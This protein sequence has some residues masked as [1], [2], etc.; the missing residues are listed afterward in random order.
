MRSLALA[1]IRTARSRPTSTARKRA[2][3]SRLATTPR[4][5][6]LPDRGRESRQAPAA[7]RLHPTPSLPHRK[8]IW[9]RATRGRRTLPLAGARLSVRAI[10][11]ATYGVTG[12]QWRTRPTPRWVLHPFALFRPTHSPRPVAIA[13]VRSSTGSALRRAACLEAAH[14]RERVAGLARCRRRRDTVREAITNSQASPYTSAL[15]R[16][17]GGPTARPMYACGPPSCE[18]PR[19]RRRGA[20]LLF[21][22]L[23]ASWDGG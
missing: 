4:S 9:A 11:S 23:Q 5:S 2:Q 1:Y 15:G 12:L 8:L 3:S 10:S 21:S 14:G 17:L 16:L 18:E 13:V 19:A 20:G 6:V 7:L 22:R